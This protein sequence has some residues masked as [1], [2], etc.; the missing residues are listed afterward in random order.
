MIRKQWAQRR[1][2]YDR[3]RVFVWK[4]GDNT[5]CESKQTMEITQYPR[6][7]SS[8]ASLI[9]ESNESASTFN[10]LSLKL[11]EDWRV[12]T[13]LKQRFPKWMPALS[14]RGMSSM[15]KLYCKYSQGESSRCNGSWNLLHSGARRMEDLQFI[16]WMIKSLHDQHRPLFSVSR[17]RKLSEIHGLQHR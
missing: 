16:T 11:L 3:S 12:C 9:T 8:L 17:K 2:L 7:N 1:F 6:F 5:I 10:S 15:M 13:W 4:E 14:R